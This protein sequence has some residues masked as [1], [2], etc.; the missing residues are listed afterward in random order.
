[1][2]NL[3]GVLEEIRKLMELK[4]ENPFKVRA[5]EKAA[6]SLA[7]REDLLE[8][9]RAGTLE[10]LPGV[11]KG[12]ATVVTEYLLEG[13][14]SVRDELVSSLPVGL[15]ELTEVPGLGPKKAMAL[16]EQLGIRSVGE[17]EYACR[18]NRLLKLKGFGP[19]VQHRILEGV[20]FR[21]SNQ[22]LRRLSDV[23]SLAE[24]LLHDLK[25]ACPGVRVSETGALRRKLEVLGELDFLIERDPQGESQAAAEQALARFLAVHS[26][27]FPV[28]LHYAAPERF[29]SELAKTTGSANHLDALGEALAETRIEAL[30]QTWVESAEEEEVYRR[31]GLSVIPPEC[32]ETGEE[33]RLARAGT[34]PSLVPGMGFVEFSIITR[35]DP[36]GPQAWSRWSRP[37]KSG[38]LSI[39]GSQTTASLPFMLGPESGDVLAEQ[40]KEPTGGSGTSE[41]HGF[42]RRLKAIFGYGSWIMMK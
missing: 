25:N 28:R 35:R 38:D 37:Q 24:Q 33:V 3:I 32:R 31:M 36:M 18:E 8:R 21:N 17:L 26:L 41:D 20:L 14:S 13:R 39:S 15:L 30:G 6:Q 40:E 29:G 5:F 34:L 4:G 22:G 12:I 16:I 27:N 7:G 23:D 10:E 2:E 42:S 19:K 9:A 1:M 11:G